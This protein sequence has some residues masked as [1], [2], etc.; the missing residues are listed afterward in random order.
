M[1][2]VAARPVVSAPA[3]SAAASHQDHLPWRQRS[4]HAP[5]RSIAVR[6]AAAGLALTQEPGGSTVQSLTEST[7]DRNVTWQPSRQ[8]GQ[9]VG[10]T[11]A[12]GAR[13]GPRAA[14]LPGHTATVATAHTP[15]HA[16][17]CVRTSRRK[18]D[19]LAGTLMAFVGAE[20]VARSGSRE[21]RVASRSV[22]YGSSRSRDVIPERLG[23][24]RH[25]L[26]DA[27]YLLA[28]DRVA[29]AV[30]RAYYAAYQGMWAALGD[31]P[32]GELWRHGAIIN[33]FVRGYW[34]APAHPATGPGLLESLRFGLRRLYELRLDV[35]YDAV[36]IS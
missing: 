26:E 18:L 3:A 34:F 23:L 16:G 33:H 21:R 20:P 7:G 36:A 25:Y 14:V 1:P 2:G 12:A 28:A 35:D 31:P 22:P 10:D 27:E 4:A 17:V 24:A 30:S 13:S 11:V 32:R 9:S 29:S 8:R 19:V 5:G 6:S 15:A